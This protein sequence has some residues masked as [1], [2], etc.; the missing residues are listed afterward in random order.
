MDAYPAAVK[1]SYIVQCVGPI[2]E[3][4]LRE[5][6][7]AGGEVRGYL[8]Y[9]SLLVIME[10]TVHARLSGRDFVEWSGLYQPYY[11]ISPAL[12][13]RLAQGGKVEVLV[14][15]FDA[16][17]VQETQ[18][19]LDSYPVEVT[20]VEADAWCALMAVSMPVETIHSVAAL[21]AVEWMEM[22]VPGTLPGIASGPASEKGLV[23]QTGGGGGQM[24]AVGDTGVGT[25]GLKGIPSP[26]SGLILDLFSLRGDDGMDPNGHGT[27]VAGVLA[28]LSS[29]PREESDTTASCSLVAYA[30]GYGLG[31][32]PLP[33]SM[34]HVLENAYLEG[35]RVYLSGGVPEGKESLGAYGI[36]A[37][38][39]DAFSWSNPTMSLVEAAGNEGTDAD[40]D[41]RV[42]KGSLLGGATAK[43]VLSVG[44]CESPGEGGEVT[45]PTY[46]Q[47][48]ELFSGRF[49]SVPLGGDPSTG[50]DRG[51]A[52]F[53]S[54]GPTRDGRIKPD[55]VAPATDI[56]TVASGGTETAAGLLPSEEAGWIRAYGTSL[57]A[58]QVAR[59]LASLRS[60]LVQG[61]EEEPSS[62]LLKAFMVNGA[63]ELS[64][65]Q[66][67]EDP[68]EISRAPNEVE[69]WG[70]MDTASF[71]NQQGWLKV[72]DD[73]EGMSLGESRT[74]KVEVPPG[75]ELRVTMAWTDY[76]SLPEARL[77]L[78]N[79]LDLIVTGPQGAVYYPNGRSSREP[80][81]NVE[82]V[83]VD[84]S[85]APGEY[86][87]EID[88]WNVPLSPQPYA[89]VAQ[90]F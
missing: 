52:A 43:N 59:Q 70:R 55:L 24:V 65:G 35:A 77:H 12:Q 75:G 45:S 38:Q 30:L 88:A 10:G 6:V 34:Y 79:D 26:L 14:E 72:L 60:L 58:A 2:R 20:M 49:D 71:Q 40:S 11:K 33:L 53:S 18:R 78:V 69:G 8:P 25:G 66:Y 76:P 5:I 64:P 19:Y 27:A 81:N 86:T 67:G 56:R 57:A 68:Q 61:M 22:S 51:M 54:R 87:I 23:P 13:L 16:D 31:S 73:A 42:D 41:G 1:A 37:C 28:G 50:A 7:E 3:S 46:G 47:L 89:L 32:P 9:N 82:R 84:V 83:V 85:E 48:Q 4:W 15:L 90:V 17:Q 44:G 63:V 36:Y 80:L 74:Y 21:P 39:R 29:V 62:A